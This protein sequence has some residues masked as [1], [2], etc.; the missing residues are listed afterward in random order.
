MPT[1]SG[2]PLLRAL[3][4]NFFWKL[5]SVVAAI[6][7]WITFA[8]ETEIST[9]IPITVQYRRVPPDLEI[10]AARLDRLFLKLKGPGARLTGGSLSHLA[11]VLDFGDI[12]YP[13]E[14]TFTIGSENLNLPA[15]ISLVRVVPSQ[16]RILI[17]RKGSKEVPV[18]P[19][20]SRQPDGYKVV[21]QQV[22][23]ARVR[24]TG[25]ESHLSKIVSARTDFLDLSST[26]A[27]Q[28][29]QVQA[30]LSDPQVQFEGDPPKVSVRVTLE[31]IP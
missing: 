15:G 12:H 2:R 23:P 29:F 9:S 7:L 3:T 11:V 19:Q 1:S 17:E 13:G 20:Y 26:V 31:K 4:Q 16:V 8:G 10:S 14:R 30:F 18:E 5:L 27:V 28:Q 22:A 6:A 24:I 21:R 25:P